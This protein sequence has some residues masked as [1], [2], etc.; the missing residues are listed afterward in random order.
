MKRQR[1]ARKGQIALAVV[2]LGF[3]LAVFLPTVWHH[4]RTDG[5]TTLI[6]DLASG[7]ISVGD[8]VSI[9]FRF[10]HPGGWGEDWDIHSVTNAEE[11]AEQFGV[12]K[13][14]LTQDAFRGRIS[15]NHP[16]TVYSSRDLELHL[17]DGSK[18]ELQ[19]TISLSTYYEDYYYSSIY[20]RPRMWPSSGPD[21]GSER[22]SS[23]GHPRIHYESQQFVLFI[24]QYDPLVPDDLKEA[25]SRNNRLAA[26]TNAP[27]QW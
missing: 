12:M 4:H 26:T 18:Y 3:M 2:V 27:S 11:I 5:L 1:L 24:S 23:S 17:R 7:A 20:A 22:R 9:E 13:R 15:K 16:S 25:T 8:V 19:Y 6:E 21:E 14:C 10:R